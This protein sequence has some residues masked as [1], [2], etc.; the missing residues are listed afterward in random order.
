MIDDKKE[1]ITIYTKTSE[2]GLNCVKGSGIVQY[3]AND[4]FKVIGDDSYRKEYDPTFDQ[5]K[6]MYKVGA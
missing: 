2:S 3:N 1:E 5:G 6:F 4:I